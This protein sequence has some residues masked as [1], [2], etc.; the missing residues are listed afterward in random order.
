M[1]ILD[2]PSLRQTYNYDCGT[3][4]I[5]AALAYFGLDV[6]ED[7]II[8]MTNTTKHGASIKSIIKVINL[9]QFKYKASQMRITD[10]KKYIDKNYP[11]I[12]SLQAWTKKK[13]VNWKNNW[14]D[15]HYVVAIGYDKNKIYFADPSSI[16]KTYLTYK[17][18]EDRWHDKDVNGKKYIN[19]GI[20]VFGRKK[21]S[22]KKFV[23]MD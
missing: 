10:L 1:K 14:S 15:G 5:Q 6:R 19:Y 12:I 22:S 11:V 16:Y 3:K 20:A 23:H 13:R 9:Y 18:L 17:E 4:A 7:K 8:K 21:Y 2:F